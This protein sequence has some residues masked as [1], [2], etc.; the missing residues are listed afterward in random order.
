[1]NTTTSE[2]MNKPTR[3]RSILVRH[4]Q[5]ANPNICYDKIDAL[6]ADIKTFVKSIINGAE[7]LGL[8]V[9]SESFV[10]DLD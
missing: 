8:E 4:L 6:E 9:K 3:L 5:A 7:D 10:G 1:M 2:K